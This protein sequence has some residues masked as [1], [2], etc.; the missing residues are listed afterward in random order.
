MV[1]IIFIKAIYQLLQCHD[2]MNCRQ[3]VHWSTV[4]FDN[5]IFFEMIS[6][7]YFAIWFCG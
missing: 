5:E 4:L 2:V 7:I 3:S 6:S 1:E